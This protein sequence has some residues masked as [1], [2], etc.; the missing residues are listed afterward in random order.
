MNPARSFGP[1]R[2]SGTWH[3]QW[4]YLIAP[5]VGAAIGVLVYEVVRGGSTVRWSRSR[6]SEEPATDG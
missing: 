4:I 6:R 1:A 3:E 2:A 5:F